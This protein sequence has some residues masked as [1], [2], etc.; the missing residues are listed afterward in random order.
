[1]KILSVIGARPQFIKA[2]VVSAALRNAGC[3]QYVVHTGQH[4]DNEMSGIFFTE[5]G[6]AEP[7]ANLDV[8]SGS[9]GYQTGEMLMRLETVLAAQK[10]D[11][12][13]I[14][15]DTNSTLAGALAAS[16]LRIR[17]AHVEAGMRSY[18]LA[19]AEEVNRV[20]S[21]HV[22]QLLF[23][24]TQTA[25]ENLRREGIANG[26]HL[27]GD[28]MYD[29]LLTFA[30][31]APGRSRVWKDLSLK[32]KSYA[33]LTLHRAENVDSDDRLTD[34][35]AA[36]RRIDF[37]IVFPVHPRTRRRLAEVGA[38]ESLGP[39]VRLLPPLG[40]L[41]TIALTQQARVV[42]T[43]SGGLQRE[44]FFLSVPS[45]ILRDTTEWPE[46]LKAGASRLAG[47]DLRDIWPPNPT[48]T[49]GEWPHGLFGDGDASSR[50]A[51]CLRAG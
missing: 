26:V 34:L 45:I 46:L 37:P 25:V 40:Y 7:D 16:K 6:I 2:A 38:L 47:T 5:L 4:Y 15:G 10:P 23:C 19:M 36:L 13:L 44:A 22:S 51:T 28:V 30:P 29:A 14:Y 8:G 27:V 3:E 50:I 49:T 35:V 43:D 18:D 24:A 11:C 21:D 9:H 12:V 42:L 33:L 32:S 48:P 41:D 20:L 1:M 39:R 17:V 31:I